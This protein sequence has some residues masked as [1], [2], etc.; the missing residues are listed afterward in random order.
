MKKVLLLLLT[1]MVAMAVTVA[2][3]TK[4]FVIYPSPQ[5]VLS[6][7]NCFS[8]N[9][10]LQLIPQGEVGVQEKQLASDFGVRLGAKITDGDA[11]LKIYYKVAAPGEV[12]LPE[13]G[14]I[15]RNAG[16]DG[17]AAIEV[18]GGDLRGLF[19]GFCSL[20]QMLEVNGDQID[21]KLL[22]VEDYP[23]WPYRYFS[24]D[25]AFPTV[26][27]FENIAYLKLGNFAW[28]YRFDWRTFKLGN[29]KV[30]TTLEAIKNIHD[31][32]MMDF[33][34]LL[35]I[36]TT[37]AGEPHFNIARE[38]DVKALAEA[39]RLAA[40]YG[41]TSIM[42]CA[43][44]HTPRKNNAYTF[45]DENQDEAD[46]FDNSIGKAHGHLMR[47]LYDELKDE[48]PDL[49]L[50]MVGAP[51]AVSHGIGKF[52]EIDRYLIDW[53]KA[54]PP[55]VA[56]VWTGVD[57]TTPYIHK[58][59]H[60]LIKGLI[61]DHDMFV[62]DNS[63]VIDA[64]MPR[65]HTE[66]YDGFRDDS[67]GVLYYNGRLFTNSWDVIYNLG[68]NDS[69]WN[70]SAYDEVASNNYAISEF[71]GEDAVA[72]MNNLRE[73]L[74]I[75]RQAFMVGDRKTLKKEL[76]ELKKYLAALDA[77]K[78]TDLEG[79][80]Y[81]SK[82]YHLNVA[83]MQALLDRNVPQ[84]EIPPIT[85]KIYVDGNVTAAEWDGAAEMTLVP[86]DNKPGE[87]HSGKVLVKYDSNGVYFAVILENP[88]E[89]PELGELPYDSPVFTHKD[90]VS[91]FLQPSAGGSYCQL[92]FDYA[93]NQYDE[94]R[95]DG[96]YAWNS[97]W[98]LKTMKTDSGW[99]AELYV[100][101]IELELLAPTKPEPGVMW[102]CNVH[103]G[104]MLADKVYSWVP[105]GWSFHQTE[106]FGELF[107]R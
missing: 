3:E 4:N 47:V 81:N 89:L 66:F 106:Y 19:Y 87:L 103:R 38:A 27:D 49:K 11:A 95:D 39:C 50:S 54:A 86:R 31:R 100:P 107:F 102:R 64:P 71:F 41:V 26:K 42:I 33:M 37:P 5:K 85:A 77:L 36:Y 68:A 15:I 28:Q 61:G 57:V 10:A 32:G 8:V 34:L 35:H 84:L 56:W 63:N 93:G 90:F 60:D 2:E 6:E 70:P 21:V 22:E 53:G 83:S 25:L 12:E 97:D 40:G 43:D 55:E 74:T 30:K 78:L 91:I 98:K 62:W 96:G 69:I 44:D 17:N 52:P 101:D 51:Y 67:N 58:D 92:T 20:L 1:G 24:D 13:H 48:F 29:S 72:I 59:A 7:V 80:P 88:G 75:C 99:N 104:D 16:S 9:N 45:F 65:W 18:I 105:G 23:Y 14:Y 73:K 82:P 79:K 94:I 46:Y 76:P